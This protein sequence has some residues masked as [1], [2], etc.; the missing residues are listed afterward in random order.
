MQL[1]D[2]GKITETDVL[3]LG[4]GAAGCGASLAAIDQGAKVLA[5]DKGSIEACGQIGPGNR[6]FHTVL[7]S[8]PEW[9]TPEAYTK[10]REYQQDQVVS[11]EIYH[12]AI[13]ER[14][15]DMFK[16]VEAMGVE[17]I[18]NPDGSYMRKPSLGQ[19]HPWA[20]EMENGRY[21]H[22]LLA[23]ELTKKG[24]EIADHIMITK[25]L[26]SADGRACGA[27]GFNIWTGEFNIFRSKSVVLCLAVSNERLGAL[28]NNNP[29]NVWAYAFNSGSSVAL[30]Y[31]AGAKIIALEK[32]QASLEPVSFGAP[33]L[34]HFQMRDVHIINAFGER[35]MF[36]YDSRGEQASRNAIVIGTLREQLEG[37]GPFFFDVRHLPDEEIKGL[38]E[39]LFQDKA[40]Y[41][42]FIEQKG[43]DLKNE[44]MEVEIGEIC[45]G[46][47]LQ[48]DER[49][50]STNRPGLFG[51]TP[52]GLTN[53]LCG[54]YSSGFEAS[55]A[56]LKI[57]ELPEVSVDLVS[58]EKEIA[59]AP[60]K[61]EDGFTWQEHEDLI[62]QVMRSYMHL[63]RNKP[64]MELCLKKLSK[65]EEHVNEIKASNFHEMLRAN[66]ALHLLKICQLM[67]IASLERTE[68]GRGCYIRTDYPD[69]DPAWDNR[70]VVLWQVNGELKKAI[71]SVK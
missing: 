70:E 13:S 61:R 7:L 33:G 6:G 9:D 25:I 36:K 67:T 65:I 43:L 10:F 42:D 53:A 20:L 49:L 38:L 59:F 52:P 11:A 26:V 14:L 22:R 5:V 34:A 45:G 51:Y 28:S 48:I 39:G 17:F 41:Q 40:L 54:G 31:D 44:P 66:E 35:Y 24:V 62:R 55:K 29:F 47:I 3:V 21:I 18:K 4:A 19:P 1:S 32:A 63:L 71:E 30:P 15:N 58:H 2:L 64:G 23:K 37:R 46:G 60:L 27:L 57:K 8:G 50:E 69:R 68:S 16:R 56:A 12:R